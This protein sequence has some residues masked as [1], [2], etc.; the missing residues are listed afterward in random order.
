MQYL[1]KQQWFTPQKS[2]TSHGVEARLLLLFLYHFM[3][4]GW[5][6]SG[7]P[8]PL[9]VLEIQG[10]RGRWAVFFQNCF[11]SPKVWPFTSNVVCAGIVG[12]KGSPSLNFFSNLLT[13]LSYLCLSFVRSLHYINKYIA[14]SLTSVQFHPQWRD[15][16]I[17]LICTNLFF[18][19]T[20]RIRLYAGMKK[21][22]MVCHHWEKAREL[23]DI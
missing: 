11:P 14:A 20:I 21:D 18:L 16:K 13:S 2:Q 9:I 15:R 1:P 23:V 19:S 4:H 17:H 10:W 22:V 3:Q 7:I 8:G 5:N 6:L 12:R